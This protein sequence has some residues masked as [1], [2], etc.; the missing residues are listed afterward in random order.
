MEPKNIG[1]LNPKIKLKGE[2]IHPIIEYFASQDFAFIAPESFKRIEMFIKV[3]NR[4]KVNKILLRS[5]AFRGIPNECVGLRSLV[6][7]ILLNTLGYEPA[8]WEGMLSRHKE[9]YRQFMEE[10]IIKPSLESDSAESSDHPLSIDI[11]SEWCM[12]FK[13][14]ELWEEIEKDVKRTRTDT[15]FF[16]SAIDPSKNTKANAQILE[17]QADLKKSEL[18]PQDIKNYIETHGDIISRILF[19]YGKLNPG[20]KYV[21]GM[22]EIVSAIYFCFFK[23]QTPY[24]SEYLE[25]DV[26]FAFSHLMSEIRD[27]FLREMDHSEDGILGKLESIQ[28]ILQRTDYQIYVQFKKK[29]VNLEFF[30]LRWAMLLLSTEFEI[31]SILRLWDSLLA[32]YERFHFFKY[33]CVALIIYMKSHIIGHEFPDILKKMQNLPTDINVLEVIRIAVSIIYEDQGNDEYTGDQY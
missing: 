31:N 16:T 20:V 9:S 8:K 30:M 1:K 2:A 15:G 14:Q 29:K 11:K 13:D 4:G 33:V 27:R 28:G 12:Y 25:S 32:D 5:L 6:W 10:L 3:F 7:R 23:D 26:F 21:Q 18:T 19:I 24:I 17:R 22:N